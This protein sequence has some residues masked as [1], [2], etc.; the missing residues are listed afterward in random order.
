MNPEGSMGKS[1]YITPLLRCNASVRRSPVCRKVGRSGEARMERNGGEGGRRDVSWGRRVVVVEAFDQGGGVDVV[2]RYPR[3]FTVVETFSFDQVLD[4]TVAETTVEY[5]LY[6]VLFDTFNKD[7]DGRGGWATTGNG[8]RGGR[9][10]LYYR[11]DVMECTEARRELEFVCSVSYL[12][13]NDVQ[14]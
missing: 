6:D 9:S 2:V 4:A 5:F 3:V 14:T 10:Q 11:E 1:P 13:V 7:W 8:I 12:L